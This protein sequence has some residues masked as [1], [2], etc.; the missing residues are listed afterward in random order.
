MVLA[1][2]P[3]TSS[4]NTTCYFR[5]LIHGIGRGV[6]NARISNLPTL[7]HRSIKYMAEITYQIRPK[8]LRA[9]TTQAKTT[10]AETTQ[11]RNDSVPKRLRT[12][13]ARDITKSIL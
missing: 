4:W 13:T 9:E 5:G 12:E 11:D 10:K 8:R 6:P 3:I 2:F 7:L 1:W